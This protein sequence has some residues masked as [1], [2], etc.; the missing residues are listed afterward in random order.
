MAVNPYSSLVDAVAVQPSHYRSIHRSDCPIC[1]T[2]QRRLPLLSPFCKCPTCDARLCLRPSGRASIFAVVLCASCYGI[3]Y[4]W[5]Y[6]NPQAFFE[7][8]LALAYTQFL[9]I[10]FPVASLFLFGRVCVTNGWRA[11]PIQQI[12]MQRNVFLDKSEAAANQTLDRSG[13]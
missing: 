6:R 12:V 9:L 3:A 5:M 11:M 13:G 2:R 1:F 7:H 10:I 8:A 4:S